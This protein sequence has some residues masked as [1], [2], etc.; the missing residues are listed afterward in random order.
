M[1]DY[2]FLGYLTYAYG[3]R[4]NIYLVYELGASSSNDS[5]R[6]LKNSLFGAV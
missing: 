1:Y 4:V 3:S 6:T 2:G 5:N